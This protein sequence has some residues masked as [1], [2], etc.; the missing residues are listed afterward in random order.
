MGGFFESLKEYREAKAFLKQAKTKNVELSFEM[1]DKAFSKFY[2]S[3]KNRQTNKTKQKLLFTYNK[4]LE[5]L[6][7]IKELLKTKQTAK[8]FILASDFHKK[9]YT[10]QT[11]MEGQK[12]EITKAYDRELEKYLCDIRKKYLERALIFYEDKNYIDAHFCFYVF[13]QLGGKGEVS[14]SKECAGEYFYQKGKEFFKE[15]NYKYSG[16]YFNLACQ[17]GKDCQKERDK[18]ISAD[19]FEEG[20]KLLKI[21]DRFIIS[22]VSNSLIRYS[23][24]ERQ[25]VYANQI[26]PSEYTQ[27]KIDY[28]R[29]KLYELDSSYKLT[30][31]Y[32]LHNKAWGAS[33]ILALYDLFSDKDTNLDDL[34]EYED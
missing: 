28:C 22:S 34:D 5:I 14:K 11:L 8:N 32:L 13:K 21:A 25:F 24:A 7:S 4:M 15:K 1:Y 19:L 6:K 16:A 29:K 12:I 20:E 30:S 17:N 26:S 3:Y 27:L 10:D 33:A 31:E 23:K 18:S 2:H 9:L